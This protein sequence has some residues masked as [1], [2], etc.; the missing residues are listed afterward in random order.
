MIYVYRGINHSKGQVY[1]GVSKD[2]SARK[3]GSH[4][5]GGTMALR[6]W[7]CEEDKIIWRIVSKHRKLGIASKQAHLFEKTYRHRL[8]FEN[9][10]TKGI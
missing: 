5:T 3:D 7:N 6:S 9:I 2:P 4:C 10:Q 1:H 8:G